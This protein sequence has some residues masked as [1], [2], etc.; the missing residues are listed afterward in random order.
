VK[1]REEGGEEGGASFSPVFHVKRT[2][3]RYMLG[4]RVYAPTSNS[5]LAT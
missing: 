1:H 2:L 4:T 5:D 3:T